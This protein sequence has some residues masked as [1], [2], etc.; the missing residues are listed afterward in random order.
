MQV[1]IYFFLRVRRWRKQRRV[2]KFESELSTT[3]ETISD[4]PT[5]EMVLQIQLLS[6]VFELNQRSCVS[7]RCSIIE[8][9]ESAEENIRNRF[10]MVVMIISASQSKITTF[11]QF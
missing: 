8:V 2:I 3:T 6:A 5:I 9:N 11:D 10:D 1:I 4:V 7:G